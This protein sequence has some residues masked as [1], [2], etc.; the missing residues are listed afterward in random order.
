[1]QLFLSTPATCTGKDTPWGPLLACAVLLLATLPVNGMHQPGTTDKGKGRY[2]DAHPQP[3]MNFHH[4]QPVMNAHHQQ[5]AMNIHRLAAQAA[6]NAPRNPNQGVVGNNVYQDAH[7][8]WPQGNNYMI[9]HEGTH[10]YHQST[11]GYSDY[12]ARNGVAADSTIHFRFNEEARRAK[13]R[14]PPK[15]HLPITDMLNWEYIKKVLPACAESSE[16]SIYSHKEGQPIIPWADSFKRYHSM[17]NALQ[18]SLYWAKCADERITKAIRQRKLFVRSSYGGGPMTATIADYRVASGGAWSPVSR[19]YVTKSLSDRLEKLDVVVK[20]SRDDSKRTKISTSY[21][22]MEG[23]LLVPTRGSITPIPVKIIRYNV[24][25]GKEAKAFK[26]KMISTL[27]NALRA[28]CYSPEVTIKILDVVVE[29]PR[30]IYV[31]T[32]NYDGSLRDMMQEELPYNLNSHTSRT[33][34]ETGKLSEEMAARLFIPFIRDLLKLSRQG[35]HLRNLSPD[36]IKVKRNEKNVVSLHVVDFIESVMDTSFEEVKNL[37]YSVNYYYD[38]KELFLRK[39]QSREWSRVALQELDLRQTSAVLYDAVV[40]EESLESARSSDYIHR[41]IP[42][43]PRAVGGLTASLTQFFE[44]TLK[45]H[46]GFRPSITNLDYLQRWENEL[47]GTPLG[48]ASA[49]KHAAQGI[50]GHY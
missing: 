26:E 2:K 38:P 40:G 18:L 36:T 12:A 7:N 34:S 30:F 42:I 32:E 27:R 3:A 9:H 44:D 25:H 37:G 10:N 19:L 33:H 22:L 8:H 17:P 46:P 6:L 45:G 5:A 47:K 23:E 21:Y 15:A 49:S 35:I 29:D 1:M 28:H 50:H 43:L 31:V 20:H 13:I 39:R 48:H 14:D 24:P 4:Q 11:H 16:E 41:D